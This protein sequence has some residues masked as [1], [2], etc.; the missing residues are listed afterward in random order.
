MYS[1]THRHVHLT[2][3]WQLTFARDSTKQDNKLFEMDMEV[4]L[5]AMHVH[6]SQTYTI[7]PIHRCTYTPMH[8]GIFD[9]TLTQLH[10]DTHNFTRT[11]VDRHSLQIDTT[12]AVGA[13]TNSEI[14]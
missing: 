14:Q 2:H 10:T 1:Y 6:E 11:H 4:C 9:N 3:Y 8:R 12:T 7:M 13:D 5:M